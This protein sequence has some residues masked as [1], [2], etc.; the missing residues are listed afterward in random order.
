MTTAEANI[1][2][3]L[4]EAYNHTMAKLI[5][6]IDKT[7]LARAKTEHPL[8]QWAA[9]KNASSCNTSCAQNCYD[10]K[11]PQNLFMNPKCMADCGCEFKLTKANKTELNRDIK[12]FGDAMAKE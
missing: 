7:I 12:N 2:D 4:S 9:L 8:M 11:S 6:N 3:A 10:P 1:L 5:L